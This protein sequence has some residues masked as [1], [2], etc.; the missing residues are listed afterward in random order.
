MAW[1]WIVSICLYFSIGT[2]WSGAWMA[3]NG[4]CW[5]DFWFSLVIF[6]FFWPIRIVVIVVQEIRKQWKEGNIAL[7]KW[8]AKWRERKKEEKEL[9]ENRLERMGYDEDYWNVR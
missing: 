5:F 1:Y 4:D 8:Y 2:Y 9:D 7:P 3:N 6:G